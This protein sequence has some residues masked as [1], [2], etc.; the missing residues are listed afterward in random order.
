[1]NAQRVSL[2]DLLEE[3]EQLKTVNRELTSELNLLKSRDFTPNPN[4][5]HTKPNGSLV[6]VK[7]WFSHGE[8]AGNVFLRS[9]T[10]H[11]SVQIP[12]NYQDSWASMIP[13][14]EIDGI[15][16]EIETA[17]CERRPFNI[18]YTVITDSG[19]C[20]QWVDSGWPAFD[21][22]GKLTFFVGTCIDVTNQKQIEKMISAQRDL[23]RGISVADTLEDAVG[24]FVENVLRVSEMDVLGIYLF[25]E[26]SSLRLKAYKGLS[27]EF[28][29][30]VSFYPPESSQALA[31]SD[32]K[33]LYLLKDEISTLLEN[34][35]DSE[36][37]LT[38]AMLPMKYKDEIIGSLNV[39]SKFHENL[40]ENLKTLLEAFAAQCAVMVVRFRAQQDL[41]KSHELV[42]S[43]FERIKDFV[44]IGNEQ[45]DLVDFNP[46]VVEKLGY[47]PHE[48]KSMKLIDL[49]PADQRE[50]ALRVVNAM[51]RGERSHCIIPLVTKSGDCIPVET[52]VSLGGW[53]D[54]QYV[55]GVSRDLTDRIAAEEALRKSEETY[56]QM[57][58]VNH[59]VKLLIDPDTADIVDA[60]QAAASFYGY[61]LED[62]KKK[63]LFD[64][65]L[66]D[67]T[68]IR[69]TMA[70]VAGSKKKY[71]STQHVN[72][73]GK[74]YDVEVFTS[75]LNLGEKTLLY[76]IVIDVSE[77][78][79]AQRKLEKTEKS[80]REA[81]ES[82]E[83]RVMQRSSELT[84]INSQ[85]VKEVEEHCKTASSL[86]ESENNLKVIIDSAPIGIVVVQGAKYRYA[87]DAFATIYGL[88]SGQAAIGQEVGCYGGKKLQKNARKYIE[89]CLN[90]SEPIE[91]R[92][93]KINLCDGG[94]RVLNVW[95]Q[96]LELWGKPS[97][98]GFYVD[99]SAEMQLRSHLN[100]S[101]KME[102]LGSLAGGIAHDFNN[103]LFAI[104][105][106]AELC[107]D[108]LKGNSRAKNY[109]DQL[110]NASERAADL[111]RHILTFSREAETEKRP[112]WISPILKE[113]LNF[114]RASIPASIEIRRNIYPDVGLVNADPTQIHQVIMNL[115]TNAA[116]SM[117]EVGG[118]LEIDLE[119]IELGADFLRA[120]PE[121]APGVY[122]R[123]SV[124]DTGSGI[125]TEI[126]DRIFDPYFTT[127]EIGQGTGLGLSVVDGIIRS[128]NGLIRVQSSAG[129]GTTFQVYLP[130]IE[131]PQE[132][133]MQSVEAINL[134]KGRILM[135]D[136]EKIV[137]TATKANLEN[138][139][140]EVQTDNDPLSALVTFQSDPYFFDLIITDMS[141]PRMNGAELAQAIWRT[142]NDM[143]IIMLSGFA[144]LMDK[145]R[146][147][148]LGL[149]DFL[150]K[151]LRRSVLADAVSSVLKTKGDESN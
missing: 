25:D 143:P 17:Y 142:R 140:Y 103:I 111:I 82:L 125:P 34:A 70:A 16:K 73:K 63:K 53:G 6:P 60:N 90:R 107:M 96:P 121:M 30:R 49:H 15:R 93:L 56:R 126:I 89:Q 91:I 43:M 32:G 28:L 55:F 130:V 120:N 37:L 42:E 131:E 102:A 128:H 86:R 150:L 117:R 67:S 129:H 151:P 54:K 108:S 11:D 123:L 68:E 24:E 9:W 137:T 145:E 80:L 13:P 100:Q 144:D 22:A 62:L 35:P 110:L 118:T 139:G 76:A 36:K 119:D 83:L 58:Q 74:V 4:A 136:D 85:L 77:R 98:I 114:L 20:Q 149:R 3:I 12:G 23:S 5:C 46:V 101:Q 99:V 97:V 66:M 78:K 21:S 105:G 61:L 147:L 79:A 132:E 14:A 47:S 109:I 69:N 75:P 72:S 127:K 59:A 115:V 18:E 29:E 71:I 2:E 38:V 44:F 48:L 41:L 92:E 40:P 31:V 135:V 122:Q 113:S 39:G 27:P 33:P 64:L 88:E 141:M 84:A 95:F 133:Q 148:A 81:N 10:G 7:M 106:F 65:S 50:E 19:K 124:R 57:F 1:M 87:N 104:T 112:M 94:E 51:L 146:A 134:V 138:L 26:E 8:G 116:H 45:G 52:K